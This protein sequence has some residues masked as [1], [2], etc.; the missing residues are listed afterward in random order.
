VQKYYINSIQNL[1]LIV[2]G[3][4]DD[5][6]KEHPDIYLAKKEN[7]RIDEYW[8]NK[9]KAEFADHEKHVK[10]LKLK[11]SLKYVEEIKRKFASNEYT[12]RDYERDLDV[13][14]ERENHELEDILFGFIPPEKAIYFQSDKL[15]G[16]E[17]SNA[18]PSA[19]RDIQD[20]GSCYAHGLYTACVF[21]LM[22]ALEHPLRA[23]AKKLKVQPPAK[24][25]SKPLELRTWGDVI[26][27]ITTAINARSN[28]KTRREAD[29]TEFYNKA[30]DQ[31]QFFKDA[32]RD[33]V[34]HTRSKPYAEGETADIIRSVETFMKRL[35]TK[36]KEQK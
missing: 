6:L 8:G 9:L 17:V 7:H 32:W 23:L 4:F 12:F 27:K 29:L 19:A 25:P 10:Y 33:V 13:L 14:Q 5:V 28:P 3:L 24:N 1:A 2:F 11:Q 30:A 31:F 22:R 18:F 36:L 34:M 26:D 21:H 35:A 20:A 15:F 16:A